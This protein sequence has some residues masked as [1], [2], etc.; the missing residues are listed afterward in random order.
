MNFLP[1]ILEGFLPVDNLV[2]HSDIL[3]E[4]TSNTSELYKRSHKPKK[5]VII[6]G[7]TGSGTDTIISK[8]PKDKYVRW[9]TWTTRTEVRNDEFD[10]DKYVRVDRKTFML[11]AQKGNFIEYNPDYVANAYGTHR[12]EAEE[13]F[14]DGRIPVLQIDPTGTE[15]LNSFW[16]DEK[17]PFLEAN[18]FH[19]YVI[20]PTA[21][22]LKHR[23]LSREKD[24]ESAEKRFDKALTLLPYAKKAHYILV[25]PTDMVEK[26]AEA[27]STALQFFAR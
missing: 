13:A 23:L 6:T 14:T 21:R 15:N 27:V 26:A 1:P 2:S 3:I 18:L 9:R 19:F 22:E 11:E 5:I 12:R 8:L 24:K 10:K 4:I 7:P 16:L 17:Y 20:P 25:N